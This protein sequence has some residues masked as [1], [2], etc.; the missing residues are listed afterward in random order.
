MAILA[1][2][3]F[4]HLRHGYEWPH[5]HLFGYVLPRLAMTIAIAI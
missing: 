4:G 5:G 3:L 1:I 2:A